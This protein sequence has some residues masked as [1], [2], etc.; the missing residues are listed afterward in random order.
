MEEVTTSLSQFCNLLATAAAV[1]GRRHAGECLSRTGLGTPFRGSTR[2]VR[3][4]RRRHVRPGCKR[5][6]HVGV[7]KIGKGTK[8][9]AVTE[10][11]GLPVGVT[12]AA[13]NVS[14]TKLIEP[15]L[16]AI[17]VDGFAPQHLLYDKAADSDPLRD[18]LDRRG[19]ELVTPHRKNRK[20]PK[21][22]DGRA[23]RRYKRRFKVEHLNAKLK[24][25]R[26]LRVRYEYLAE[27]FE[28]FVHLACILILLREFV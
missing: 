17:V 9:E 14:E 4:V 1:G 13:A 10:G 5:G 15:T 19:V 23:L 16:D 21:R 12:I 6:D 20:R 8:V 18:Q 27:M 2:L 25:F 22:Q 28:A 3:G 26:R 24:V 11:R 7:T